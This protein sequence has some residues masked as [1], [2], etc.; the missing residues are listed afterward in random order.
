MLQLV[1]LEA[2]S[3]EIFAAAH[4]ACARARSLHEASRW[5]VRYADALRRRSI[6]WIRGGTDVADAVHRRAVWQLDALVRGSAPHAYCFACS[7][8]KLALSEAQVR[9]AA[10]TLVAMHGFGLSR[11][12]C[13][14]CGLS[15]RL[16]EFALPG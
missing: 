5:H 10:Q 6:R 7:A 13:H 4:R 16:L 8:V 12:E 11:R 1:D 14:T 3:A 2:R 15:E 9:D